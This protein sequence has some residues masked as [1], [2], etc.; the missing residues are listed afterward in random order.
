MGVSRFTFV[1]C[2]AVVIVTGPLAALTWSLVILDEASDMVPAAVA[3]NTTTTPCNS[4]LTA[5]NFA[6]VGVMATD[7]LL[8]LSLAS[9]LV[10]FVSWGFRLQLAMVIASI[11]GLVALQ[12]KVSTFGN[13]DSLQQ[14][15]L[16]ESVESLIAWSVVIASVEFVA[17]V[18]V[19]FSCT[20][21]V[22]LSAIYRYRAQ[23]RER[24]R[25]ETIKLVQRPEA[26]TTGRRQSESRAGASEAELS[27]TTTGISLEDAIEIEDATAIAPDAE[28]LALP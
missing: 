6:P 7:A 27:T 18:A 21:I 16:R 3:A 5:T 13:D 26:A 9:G 22:V 28:Q 15:C 20:G 1:V 12:I 10:A 25:D 14:D 17:A 8:V 24:R 11:C 19:F 2:T 23:V 4:T